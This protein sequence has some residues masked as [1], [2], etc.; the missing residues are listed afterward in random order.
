MKNAIQKCLLFGGLT[1]G[2]MACGDFNDLNVNPNQPV[3]VSSPTLL[4]NAERSVSSIAGSTLG[5]IYAQHIA[6]ITYTEDGR[7]QSIQRDFSDWY[8]GPLQNLQTYIDL[9]TNPETAPDA[10]AFGSNA[11]QIAAARILQSYMYHFMTD[12]WGPLPY[13][14]SLKGRDGILL[15][16]YDSQEDIYKGIIRTLEEAVALFDDGAGPSGDFIFGGDVDRWKQFAQTIKMQAA[17]RLSDVDGN[18]AAQK[19]NEA[20]AAGVITED[21]MYPYLAEANNQ[22]PWFAAFITRTDFAVSEHMVDYLKATGDPRLFS[23]AD[24]TKNSVAAGNPEIIGMPYGLANSPFEPANVS[25][26]NSTYIKA[27]DSPLPIY[28]VAQVEFAK[29][30]AAARGWN[31]ENAEAHYKAA[32]Q[33]SLAQWGADFA[34]QAEFD[35]FYSHPDVAWN[36]AD[37]KTNYTRQKWVGTFIQGYEFW[38]E[39][40]RLDVP[41]LVIGESLL[42]PSKDIPKRFMYSASEA[43]L[44]GANYQAAL[45]QWLGGE[46]YDGTRLWW[47]VQ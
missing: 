44:N 25:F 30:E 41:I 9:N 11:N 24:P 12:L 45:D 23:F 2:L 6:E 1:F 47:D 5:A 21:I 36:A 17:L 38:A 13:S 40:R 15:P 33:A 43:N 22:N 34:S 19:F 27:Q 35:A 20:I 7:Y 26:P 32:I 42:N 3:E 37:W 8:Y 31:A 14:E 39:F 29:A 18:Y 28:T 46:N 4:T 10:S 16:A